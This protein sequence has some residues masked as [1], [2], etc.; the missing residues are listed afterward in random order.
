MFLCV[1]VEKWVICLGFVRSKTSLLCSEQTLYYETEFKSRY[2]FLVLSLNRI[3]LL[4][5]KLKY[6]EKGKE[7]GSD[8]IGRI[9]LHDNH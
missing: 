8:F 2:S 9:N 3:Y 5:V 1:P 7:I 6:A 4:K